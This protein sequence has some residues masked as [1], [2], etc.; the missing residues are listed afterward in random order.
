M[1][2]K[3]QFIFV[4]FAYKAADVGDYEDHFTFQMVCSQTNPSLYVL[5]LPS[6]TPSSPP[7]FKVLVTFIVL[8]TKH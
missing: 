7:A 8:S 1:Q 3:P 6:I 5:N 4:V 2:R